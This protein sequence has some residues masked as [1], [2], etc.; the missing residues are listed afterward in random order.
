MSSE[1]DERLKDGRFLATRSR[2]EDG[3]VSGNFSPPEDTQTKIAGKLCEDRLLFLQQDRVVGPEED[4]SNGVLAGLRKD[5]AD[6]P[7]SLPFE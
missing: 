7:L 6:V 5:A 4:V 2:T 1:D 3:A